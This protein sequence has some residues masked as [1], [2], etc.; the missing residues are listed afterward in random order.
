MHYLPAAGVK[1]ALGSA[2]S[3]STVRVEAAAAWT[4]SGWSTVNTD[5]WAKL[6]WY[7][8]VCMLKLT[9]I[10]WGLHFVFNKNSHKRTSLSYAVTQ[11]CRECFRNK[12]N[13]E[14][15][16][17]T[18]G[19]RSEL[20][21]IYISCAHVHMKSHTWIHTHVHTH[22]HERAHTH[23]QAHGHTYKHARTYTRTH[24]TKLHM[25][26]PFPCLPLSV[27]ILLPSVPACKW[28]HRT[29]NLVQCG[30]STSYF[31]VSIGAD[32]SGDTF[33]C[34]TITRRFDS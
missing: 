32:H 8:S 34:K 6:C 5:H 17:N 9:W 19:N 18:T 14:E 24:N 2:C 15:Q 3:R 30:T 16:H 20:H 23:T 7:T 31:T 13:Q 12:S 29:G 27:K 1:G 22:A 11:K 10:K 25:H 33:N 28:R 21:T 26:V 4:S